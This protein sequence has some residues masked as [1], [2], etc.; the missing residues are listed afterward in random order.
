[1]WLSIAA[2]R[3]SLQS[4]GMEIKMN[5]ALKGLQPEKVFMFFEELTQIPH[6]S[7]NTRQISDFCVDFAKKRGLKVYRDEYNNVVI[8]RPA[9]AG[10]ENA[11]GVIIQGHLDMVCEK[12]TGC[13]HDFTKD[14]LDVYVEDGYVTARGTTLGGDDG[15]A[16]AYAL[17][18]LDDDSIKAPAI[19]AVFTV[20][21]E[22]GLDGAKMLDGTVLSSK[23]LI[24]ID[25]EE[26]G[27]FIVGCAGGMRSGLRLPVS[28]TSMEGKSVKVT[29]T[30]L[31]GGH[32]GM[33]IN[34]GRANAHIILGRLLFNLDE[35]LFY[36]IS[37]LTG[38]RMDNAIS[39]ECS[40]N[41]CIAPEDEAHLKELCAIL[42]TQL[43]NEYSGTDDG[44][45]IVVED[46]GGTEACV[47]EE[48]SKQA[49]I[50]LLMNVP[51]GVQK[52]SGHIEG[53]VETSLNL[54][55]LSMDEECINIS[56]SVRSSVGSAKQALADKLRYLI[57]F[58]GGEYVE[59]GCYPEWA[60]RPESAFRDKAV[61]LYE[62]M[63]GEKANVCVIHAGLECGLFAEKL[64]QLDMI[65]IGPD[66]KDIHTPAEK[67]SVKSVEKIWKY[68]VALLESMN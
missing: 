52:L 51:N 16:I 66:M 32:S 36:G 26:E 20:D 2:D 33:E 35:E 62:D 48:K 12:E 8:Y 14:A 61:K 23:Y 15:I 37:S 63:F 68:L 24:N 30:G 17:A 56:F 29:I 28:Y 67:L 41:L 38:G 4:S 9:S 42:E 55:I 22:V 45:K 31:L 54:G 1:M 60:Y 11:P 3:K 44:I 27:A 13:E 18:V 47:I 59:T 6:G 53:L 57:E 34:K 21:E 43:R 5:N 58:F 10:Y 39:R 46:L 25:N 50:F 19:E 49:F 40:V 64:P 7:H 65:S